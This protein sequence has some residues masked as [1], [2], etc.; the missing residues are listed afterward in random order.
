MTAAAVLLSLLALAGAGLAKKPANPGFDLFIFVRSYS[1]TFC[2]AE[3]CTRRPVQ[4]FTIHGLWPEYSNGGWPEWCNTSDASGGGGGQQAAAAAG[5]ALPLTQ[6]I[7]EEEQ[8]QQ[9]GEAAKLQQ[10]ADPGD[11]DA[12]W[13]EADPAAIFLAG[14]WKGGSAASLSKWHPHWHRKKRRKKHHHPS[15]PPPPPPEPQSP[16][17]QPG[18]QPDPQ[19]S[20]SPPPPPR[21]PAM[22]Q[23]CEWPSFHGTDEA[24][25][26]HEWDRHGSCAVPVTGER[27]DFFAAV[28]RL[29]EQ[30]DLDLALAAA[31]IVPSNETS[32]PARAIA[33]A[34]EDAFRVPPLL[35]CHH[36]QLLE[37]WLCVGLDLQVRQ[38]PP[39]VVKAFRPTCGK[40]ISLPLGSA[41]PAECKPFFPP[42]NAPGGGS[43]AHAAFIRILTGLVAAAA[44]AAAVA[45]F[46]RSVALA[47]RPTLAEAF[48]EQPYD[49]L[50]SWC[51]PKPRSLQ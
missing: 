14:G 47:R 24:F 6:P 49:R 50:A 28:M 16:A 27:P 12:E 11:N 9:Q 39:G 23:Q 25:W 7:E 21:D 18:P 34:V 22:Q 5:R 42:W 51:P 46:V 17:P 36:G 29:H 10:Q 26:Q 32:Y 45:L 19:P 3:E 15:P 31:S 13:E 48:P 4:A 37:V 33:R 44:G 35:N 30:F 38:C 41:V 1:P 43:G 8:E 20:P 40:T 2:L